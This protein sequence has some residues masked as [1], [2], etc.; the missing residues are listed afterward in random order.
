VPDQV[1]AEAGAEEIGG[2]DWYEAPA[3]PQWWGV[4]AFVLSLLGFGDALYLTIE[5]FNGT[6]P[7][8]AA[9]GVINC[10]KVT[11]SPQSYFLHIPVALLG[12]LFFAA[13]IVV[14]VPPLWRSRHEWVAWVRLAMVSAGL[15]SVICLV[16][17]EVFT[18]KAVCLWC[19]G[20]HLI[21]VVL[22]ILVLATF[23]AVLQA[24]RAWE[25]ADGDE[26]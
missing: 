19:T 5:H 9:S 16:S 23:P 20:V 4:T 12:L 1:D 15:V 22:F 11:T 14:N 10:A 25:G 8:C 13:M 17:A 18:I 6:V 2:D 21:S 26:A 7:I 3:V 24:A